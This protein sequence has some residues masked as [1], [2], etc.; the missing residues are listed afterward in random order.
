LQDRLAQLVPEDARDRL[1]VEDRWS[2]NSVPSPKDLARLVREHGSDVVLIDTLA[3]WC[4]RRHDISRGIPEQAHLDLECIRQ[5]SGRPI[6]WIGVAHTRKLDRSG[7]ITDELEELAGTIGR[8]A[9]CAI[10][11]R[12]E[13]ADGPR[14]KVTFAKV[15]RGPEPP[16]KIA[17]LPD[18]DSDAPPR[19]N[20]QGCQ[21]GL[22]L[23]SR[24]VGGLGGSPT[25]SSM[26]PRPSRRWVGSR[27]LIDG[28]ST[29]PS[30]I[31][32]QLPVPPPP[33]S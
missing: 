29:S 27:E 20:R 3:A 4:Q 31:L 19:P 5:I 33:A 7:S 12:R 22:P 26:E 24:P 6:A 1:H 17:S 16:Q 30:S 23:R 15:R 18:V 25:S 28:S 32:R 14:R 11:V 8:K 13:G 10:V 21:A 9:D 2:H